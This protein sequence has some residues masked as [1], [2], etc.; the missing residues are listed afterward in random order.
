MN[1]L[2]IPDGQCSKT[3]KSLKIVSTARLSMKIDKNTS[4]PSY[5]QI[6][7]LLKSEIRDGKF[8]LGGRLPTEAEL[9]TRSKL[10]RITVRKGIE[11]L[12]NEGWVVRKQ[13]LGTFVQKTV[14]QNLADLKTITEVLLEQCAHPRVKVLKFA[15]VLPPK[16]VREIFRLRDD[17][18]ML[19]I[20]RLFL[21]DKRPI[22]R[23]RTFMPLALRKHAEILRR[24]GIPNETT[25]SIW[26]TLGIRIKGATYT[27]RA[28]RGDRNDAKLLGLKLG[29]PVLVLERT[30]YEQDGKPIDVALF[31]YHWDRYAFSV[32][33]PRLNATAL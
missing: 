17:E 32:S 11:V 20:E 29:E 6:A 27:L 33:L 4:T 18:K 21:D 3:L 22:A 24:D 13:G 5:L 31:H 9:V 14:N 23:L 19:Q 16:H 15:P 10:S 26:E 12:E 1:S 8:P 2:S 30:T 28:A 7:E 25:Y